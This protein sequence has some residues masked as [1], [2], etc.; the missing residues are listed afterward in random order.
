MEP[1]RI[2]GKALITGAS[3]FIGGRLRDTLID[4]G[5]DVIAVRRNGSPP[6]KRGRS[7]ELS[8]A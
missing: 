6:A 8:Y 5:V 7:V 1:P 4:Q 2:E 3:G